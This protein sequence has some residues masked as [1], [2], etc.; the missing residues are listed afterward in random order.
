M[1]QNWHSF[2]RILQYICPINQFLQVPVSL[3][4]G[5]EFP[6]LVMMRLGEFQSQSRKATE[7][8]S[9][10]PC[11]SVFVPIDVL[12]ELFHET[13]SHW[14]QPSAQVTH[15][16]HRRTNLY[17]SGVCLVSPLNVIC[18]LPY[19]AGEN[20]KRSG[21]CWKCPVVEGMIRISHRRSQAAVLL[22]HRC[23]LLRLVGLYQPSNWSEPANCPIRCSLNVGCTWS[24]NYCLLLFKK[25][26]ARMKSNLR[27]SPP[28]P[29]LL[30][31]TLYP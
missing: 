27:L 5:K 30:F 3:P 28:P 21:N 2:K 25:I 31:H 22:G 1:K 8:K 11:R 15:N 13:H 12:E 24:E 17:H 9:P 23:L 16:L 18:S 26:L 20:W 19:S 6:I 14:R 10:C 4:L 7:N 29:Q